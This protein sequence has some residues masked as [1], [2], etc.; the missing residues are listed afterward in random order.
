M[1]TKRADE[2]AMVVYYYGIRM[3]VLSAHHESYHPACLHL[4]RYIGMWHPLGNVITTEV[5]EYLVLDLACRQRELNVAYTIRKKFGLKNPRLTILLRALATSNYRLFQKVKDEVNQ[6][7]LRIIEFADDE[8][9]MHALKCIG[10]TYLSV[11]L[12]FLED[13]TER[14]WE[15]LV[16]KDG[17]GWTLEDDRVIIRQIKRPRRAS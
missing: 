14:K 10:K 8:M 9:R 1:A 6:F 12:K 11:S 15:K 4:L 2:F 16:Q 13:T 17:V 3:S 5:A 7:H